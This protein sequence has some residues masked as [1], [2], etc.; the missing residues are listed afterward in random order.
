VPHTSWTKWQ[1]ALILLTSDN[2]DNE[3]IAHSSQ[4]IR[5][6]CPGEALEQSFSSLTKVR[7]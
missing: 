7:G 6:I 1:G 2:R 4:A 3:L 5:S